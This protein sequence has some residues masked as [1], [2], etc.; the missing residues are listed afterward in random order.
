M[1]PPSGSGKED[2]KGFFFIYGHGDH[3]GL[4]TKIICINFSY[5]IIRRLHQKFKL[6]SIGLMVSEKP[7]FNILMELQCERPWLKDQKSTLAFGTYLWP[8]SN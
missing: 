3:L 6:S 2:F 5:L 8:L 4:L 1:S 7:C